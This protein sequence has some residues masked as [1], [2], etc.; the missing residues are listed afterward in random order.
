MT[1]DT[2]PSC[3]ARGTLDAIP[4]EPWCPHY[5][6]GLEGNAGQM[7]FGEVLEAPAELEAI[8]ER[9]EAGELLSE[10]SCSDREF[11][12]PLLEEPA[13]ELEA[14]PMPEGW[15][16][17][18]GSPHDTVGEQVEAMRQAG[19]RRTRRERLEARAQ[20]R[21]Q[22]AG[23][24]MAEADRA[25]ERAHA[26]ADGIPRPNHHRSRLASTSSPKPR[27][28]VRASPL[29]VIVEPGDVSATKSSRERTCRRHRCHALTERSL[30]RAA[31]PRSRA[32]AALGCRQG[33]RRPCDRPRAGA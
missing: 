21:R 8:A 26:I 10:K 24:R 5:M 7:T 25:H 33:S 3:R 28:D 18:D 19:S 17:P 22:W 31:P 23:A 9:I 6:R 29:A 27:V 11:L 16:R 32:G 12:A 15:F 30:A 2:C 20:R 1:E 13:G 14:E 4:H